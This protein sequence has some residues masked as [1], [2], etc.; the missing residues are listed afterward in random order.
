MDNNSSQEGSATRE[1][2]ILLAQ[3]NF[4]SDNRNHADASAWEMTSIVWGAQTL[5]LGFILEAMSNKDVQILIIVIGVVGLFLCGFNCLTMG[6]RNVVSNA[7]IR[8]CLRVEEELEMTPGP[9][10]FLNRVYWK[11]IQTWSFVVINIL[12][13]VAWVWVI[14]T[15]FQLHFQPCTAY[16]PSRNL[17]D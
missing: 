6:A 17:L 4:A 10:H 1:D 12:F 13:A 11:R 9:Q 5:L 15:A 3:Y 8:I 7:M 16:R 14:V 2:E